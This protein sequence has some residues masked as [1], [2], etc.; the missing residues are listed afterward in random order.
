MAEDVVGRDA[1]ITH[2]H[3]PPLVMADVQADG[4]RW[5]AAA[6]TLAR[7]PAQ[8]AVPVSA[9]RP[10]RGGVEAPA[11]ASPG[12][13]ADYDTDWARRYPARLARAALVEA[14][15][16]ARRRRRWPGP[17]LHG[18]RPPRR[19]WRRDGR[20][21]HLRR[22]PPQPRRHAAAAH[23]D[24]RAVAPPAVRGGG[25]RLL[26]PHPA[27]QR[28]CRPSSSAP[29]PSSAPRSRRRSADRAADLIDDGWSML[30][31]PE[32]G[33]SPDGWGQPFRGGAAYLALRCGVPVVPVHIEGTGRILRKG[34]KLP[35]PGHGQGHLRRAAAPAPRARTAGRFGATHR[36]GGGRPGRRGHAPTGG[37]P[38]AGPTPARRPALTGPGAPAW[39]RAWALGDPDAPP[40]PPAAAL[41]REL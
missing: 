33:R 25:R 36:A 6:P 3:N 38:A 34:R 27:H 30:I 21:G 2:L 14:R 26:L 12:P 24:P 31:F 20:A 4:P 1:T 28:R 5:L 40:H 7:K 8:A 11:G 29:S 35:T 22:Q 37:R 10:C 23:L 19:A 17:E 32:G 16:P 15:G 13:G 18:P 41:A 9:R 39:R